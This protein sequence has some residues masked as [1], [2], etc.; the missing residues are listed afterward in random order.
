M[1]L[2]LFLIITELLTFAML[3][4][5][6]R[7]RSQAVYYCT[8][9]FNVIL[10]L[11][12]WILFYQFKTYKGMHDNPAHIRLMMSMAGTSVAVV[13]PRVIMI[14]LHYSGKLFRIR[15]GGYLAWLTG[16]GI[17]FSS[18]FFSIIVLS[19]LFG[20]FNFKTETVEVKVSN[21]SKDLD[22]LRIVQISDLHLASFYSHKK[23]LEKAMDQIIA[24]KPDLLLNTGDFVSDG[25]REFD[26]FDTILCR[27][28]GRYGNFAVLGN[29][30]FGAY[31]PFFTE[32]DK[33]DNVS[34]IIQ[35]VI[36][37]GYKV[38]TDTNTTITIGNSK[39]GLIG[40]NTMGKTPYFF[41]GDVKK[42]MEGLGQT[43]LRI[44]L[45]H[46]PNQW[47]KDVAGKTDIDLTLSGHTH[48]MQ[49]G[50][51]TKKFR[52]SPAV[53]FYPHWNGLYHEGNQFHYVNRG[54]GVLG[55][56]FR[57]WMPPEITL[58]ILKRV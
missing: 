2:Y 18:I 42:A 10:S 22:G 38:L 54:M 13:L 34:L 12:F 51:Y 46:D 43:D 32:A 9:I 41:Y 44:L 26:S 21:L 7:K 36:A 17:T 1:L 11:W 53:K 35:K 50:I 55:M 33:R 14:I 56:P 30:D 45:S 15:R 5:V 6:L 8:V 4:E 29:H 40:I 31:H 57:I 24:L 39:I 25:W 20:R 27:P 16:A 47:T 58:I 28:K 37:S 49:M 19:T 48:G 52:W 23:A 3:N